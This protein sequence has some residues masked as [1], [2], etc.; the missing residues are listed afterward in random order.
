LPKDVTDLKAEPGDSVIRLSWKVPAGVDHVVVTR[1]LSAGGEERVVYSGS[2][3]SYVDRAVVNGLE[4]RY[5]VVSFDKSGTA[6]AGV[7]V[8][9]LPKATLLRSPKDG[10]KLK[11]PPTLV[12]VRNAEASYY[13]VQL[14]RGETKILSVW[15][16]K[17][18]L[19][20]PPRW[21]YQ[22]RTYALSAGIYRWYVWPGF[23]ARAAVDY[24]ELLGFSSFTI[25]R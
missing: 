13:N 24:G 25:V 11:K 8:T 16:I 5:L 18:R 22:K 17:S 20:L 15:P 21:K 12:W 6:S 14:F 9:A 4:Y 3:G 7:A 2:A 19:A 10:A 23:G 1:K